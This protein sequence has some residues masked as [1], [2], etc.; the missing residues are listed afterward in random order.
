MA[1]LAA[2]YPEVHSI[3]VVNEAAH[4]KIGSPVVKEA[5]GGGG[6]SGYDDVVAVHELVREYFPAALLVQNDYDV[7]KRAN[8][9][10]YDALADALLA[11]DVLDALGCQAHF[12]EGRDGAHVTRRLDHLHD[13]TGLPILIT[14]LEFAIADDAAQLAK[15]QDVFPA[16]W[17]HPA[18]AGV[19]LW[20]HDEGKMWRDAGY[21]VEEDGSDRVA[22]AWLRDYLAG[23]D[24]P[25]DRLEAEDFDAMLGLRAAAADTAMTGAE[26][27]E[28]LAFRRVRLDSVDRFAVAYADVVGGAAVS[29]RL[30]SLGAAPIATLT[31]GATGGFDA[32]AVAYA[33][34]PDTLDGVR[35]VYVSFA[36]G[37]GRALYDDYFALDRRPAVVADTTGTSALD[38]VAFSRELRVFPNPARD[39]VTVEWA[40][41]AATVRLFDG[42]GRE[43]RRASV[44]AG[45]RRVALSV[46]GLTPG[47][48][49]L[50]V[51]SAAGAGSRVVVVR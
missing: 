6:E 42:L 5:F 16:M 39:R 17:E 34:L 21:L 7:L 41:G 26:P 11:A 8:F 37:N 13:R 49:V 4:G 1:A 27:G 46:E 9:P 51:V 15:W 50:Q 40:G 47:R 48:Y 20:G 31:G 24:R 2:R 18:V 25:G 3:D 19:T 35:D 12:L 29:L 45:E 10:E 43:A 32:F 28:Y 14:E 30:D 22:L 33:D 36:G 23:P 38:P 44:A